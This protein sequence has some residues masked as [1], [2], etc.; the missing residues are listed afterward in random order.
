MEFYQKLLYL[1]VSHT[2]RLSGNSTTV[3][4]KLQIQ[5]ITQNY[6]RKLEQLNPF[7]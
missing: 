1:Q 7:L 6:K 4:H 5:N 3:K 2:A